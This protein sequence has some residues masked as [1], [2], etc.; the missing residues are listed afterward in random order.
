MRRHFFLLTGLTF[1]LYLTGFAQPEKLPATNQ[2]QVYRPTIQSVNLHLANLFLSYPVVDLHA[3]TPLVLSFDDLDAD[4]KDYMYTIVHCD[5]NWQPTEWS[6]LEYID[7]YTE[8]RINDYRFSFNTVKPYTHYELVLP[9]EFMRW[10]RSGTYLLQV[11]D[12]DNDGELVLTRRFVV[13]DRKV[14]IEAQVM[15]PASVEK[16][17]T[18]Q[19]IDFVVNHDNFDIR[20]PQ[21]EIS[22]CVLQNGRWD[23]AVTDIPPLFI[24]PNSLIFDYQDKIVFAGGKE[25][26][27]IDLRSLRFYGQRVENV[28]RYDDGFEAVI[29]KDYDRSEKAYFFREDA[30]GQF[31]IDNQD[32]RGPSELT[33]DY[34]NV[35]FRLHQENPFFDQ[36]VYLVN[37]LTDWQ[38]TPANRMVHN[39]SE[40]AYVVKI[41]MKQGFHDYAYATRSQGS[42]SPVADLSEIEGNSHETKNDYIILLYYRAFG[43]RY[44]QVI[45]SL[46]FDTSP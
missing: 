44:D 10:T 32:V 16:M 19:E 42:K 15:R 43:D 29:E 5:K 38:L 33:A 28:V 31:V 37:K 11:F 36:E 39:E 1:C 23:N 22:A 13:V 18:H 41:P 27:W 40:N 14:K 9:N 26:R 46:T 25:F 7:G 21:V 34:V 17:R 4:V 12:D 45:G 35:L 30:N 3:G 24:R 20:S 2:N 6:Q 8:D